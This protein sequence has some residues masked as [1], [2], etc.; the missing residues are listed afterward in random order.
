MTHQYKLN[1]IQELVAEQY[2][3]VK[4]MQTSEGYYRIAIG[5][6]VAIFYPTTG[7]LQVQGKD[8]EEKQFL[9]TVKARMSEHGTIV[10][11]A[12]QALHEQQ[13]DHL[14]EM[15]TMMG[16]VSELVGI[17]NAQRTEIA[18]LRSEVV[19]LQTRVTELEGTNQLMTRQ[20]E[21][22]WQQMQVHGWVQQ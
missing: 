12:R 3:D 11:T 20:F 9:L 15:R 4:W 14:S 7:K 16:T 8:G 5:S 1:S 10:S 17:V 18:T 13:A 22:M 19:S 6:A 2:P 21:Q